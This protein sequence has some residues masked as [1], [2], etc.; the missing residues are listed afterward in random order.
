M[1]RTRKA[2]IH[3][4]LVQAWKSINS[5][6]AKDWFLS[7]C[8]TFVQGLTTS[9][10]TDSGRILLCLS[11]YLH[12]ISLSFPLCWGVMNQLNGQAPNFV[13]V[14][15]F[16]WIFKFKIYYYYFIYIIIVPSILLGCRISK[17][18]SWIYSGI[19][20]Q[21]LNMFPW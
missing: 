3:F 10:H 15:F 16:K 14:F 21:F 18:S 8:S 7:D 11:N 19:Y 17:I 13:L 1:R 4:N 20:Y 2:H 6:W 9:L 12:P 5:C